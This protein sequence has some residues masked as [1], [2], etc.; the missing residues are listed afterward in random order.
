MENKHDRKLK[1][2]VSNGGGEFL[3]NQFKE[4]L[5]K[6]GFIHIFSPPET[7]QHNGYAEQENRTILEKAICLIHPTNLSK[8]FW[9]EAIDTAVLL[10]NLI[11]TISRNNKSPHLLWYNNPGRI[12]RLK[13]FGFRAV[14]FNHHKHRD[15]KLAPP[16]SEGIFLGDEN[17]NTSY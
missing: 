9:A 17:K 10:S 8:S 14:I 13:T 5:Y 6:C 1:K 15:W 2:L 3:N 7:P 12:N 16:G 11:P 4:L